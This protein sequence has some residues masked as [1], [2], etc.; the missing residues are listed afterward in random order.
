M[1]PVIVTTTN[2]PV[3]ARLTAWNLEFSWD[4]RRYELRLVPMQH[5]RHPDRPHLVMAMDGT[6]TTADEDGAFPIWGRGILPAM[7][8]VMIDGDVVQV[9]DE[10]INQL[11]EDM[12]AAL[13]KITVSFDHLG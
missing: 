2:F 13:E 9:P 1:N 10:A 8:T 6:M 3:R 12:D 7:P 4:G 11:R 5:E